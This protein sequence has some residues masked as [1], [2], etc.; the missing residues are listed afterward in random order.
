MSPEPLFEEVEDDESPFRVDDS[1]TPRPRR[2]RRKTV[3]LVD[4]RCEHCGAEAHF[5][6]TADQ[7]IHRHGA[8]YCGFAIVNPT[9]GRQATRAPERP[10]KKTSV[11]L[12]PKELQPSKPE[13]RPPSKRAK[14][15]KTGTSRRWS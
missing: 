7:W 8:E 9:S 3:E 2:R 11:Y 5:V 10:T 4:P 1:E 14:V 13:R 6:Q 15:V 12:L